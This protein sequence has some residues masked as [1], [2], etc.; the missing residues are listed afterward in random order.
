MINLKAHRLILASQ[1][2]RRKALLKGL[3]VDFITRSADIDEVYPDHLKAEEI[4][5]YLAKQKAIAMQSELSD[6]DILITADTIV[7]MNNK[8]INK[9]LNKE[10]AFKIISE[11][12]SNQ[13][14]V[15]TGVQIS[16][17]QQTISFFSE[18]KVTFSHLTKSEINYYLDKYQP[19]DKAGAYGIQEWIGYIGI[20]KIEGSYFNVMGFPVHQVYQK[21]K[22]ILG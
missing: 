15:Y 12:S 20:E 18:T 21:L 17:K 1:S 6:K 16:T 11:L 2:P 14:S 19:F 9:P 22:Q 10:D 8:A 4:P 5:L 3:D 7:W 13:H